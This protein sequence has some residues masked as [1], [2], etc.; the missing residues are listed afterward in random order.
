MVDVL[1]RRSSSTADTITVSPFPDFDKTLANL[2]DGSFI[3][4]LTSDPKVARS[5]KEEGIPILS[6]SPTAGSDFDPLSM[7]SSGHS[8]INQQFGAPVTSG[9]GK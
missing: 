2:G 5:L 8:P 1:N 9:F 3:F 7:G 6:S 4:N